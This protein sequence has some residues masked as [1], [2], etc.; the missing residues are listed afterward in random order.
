MSVLELRKKKYVIFF[1]RIRVGVYRKRKKKLW[2]IVSFFEKKNNELDFASRICTY[3]GCT[4][5][6]KKRK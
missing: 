1:Y 6:N 4:G 2:M 3:G 5:K